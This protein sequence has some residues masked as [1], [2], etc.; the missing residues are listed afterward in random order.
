MNIGILLILVFTAIATAIIGVFLVLRKMSMMIDAISH[1]VLLGIVLAFMLVEDLSSPLLVLGAAIMGVLTVFF[2]EMIVKSHQ[3]SEDSAPGLVFP[4]LFSIAVII[5]STSF[6]GAHLD[7]DA[8]LL[9]KI[10]F[11][12]FDKLVIS[13]VNFGPKLLYTMFAITVINIIFVKVFFKELKIVSFDQALAATLGF[14]PVLIHYLLMTLV[15]ITAVTAFSAVGSILVVAL[16]IGPAATAILMTKDLKK[17]VILAPVFGIIN[18]VVG[19]ALALATDVNIAGMVAAITLATFLIV[20]VFEPRR[21]IIT[22]IVKRSKQK[23]EFAFIILVM[24]LNNHKDPKEISCEN[25]KNELNW[26]TVKY[27]K[28]IDKGL[29]QGYFHIADNCV[30]LTDIGQ[31]FV[32]LKIDEYNI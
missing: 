4:F 26:T 32:N 13:G 24:H 1:T 22:A 19:Y 31:E 3:A 23:D 2:T 8:V 20:L 9:G 21:G 12:P 27:Q 11:A 28:Q 5:I 14:V 6:H 7:I 17:T 18:S 10:E 29:N 30:Y 16:M 25:I 15:S